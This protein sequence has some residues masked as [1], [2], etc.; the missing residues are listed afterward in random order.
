[1]SIWGNSRIEKNLYSGVAIKYLRALRV[2]EEESLIF[3]FPSLGG[4]NIITMIE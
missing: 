3:T 2:E 4:I 1:M